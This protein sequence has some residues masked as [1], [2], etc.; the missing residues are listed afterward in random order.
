M[1][2]V[3]VQMLQKELLY[4]WISQVANKIN[5]GIVILG[6]DRFNIEYVN[7]IFSNI[8]GYTKEEVI[9]ERVS[10]LYGAHTATKDEGLR[11]GCA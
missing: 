4:S 10:I 3:G 8:T 9:G 11:R 7:D 1:G 6:A 5:S 2:E